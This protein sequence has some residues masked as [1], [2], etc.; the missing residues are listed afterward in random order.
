MVVEKSRLS[1]QLSQPINVIRIDHT[2]SNGII[3]RVGK[4]NNKR[5]KSVLPPF[6]FYFKKKF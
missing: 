2:C 5:G 3:F 6:Y 4:W 1:G